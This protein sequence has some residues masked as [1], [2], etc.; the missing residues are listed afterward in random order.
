MIQFFKK[1]TLILLLLVSILISSCTKTKE[2]PD[3]GKYGV[4]VLISNEGTF[5]NGNGTISYYNSDNDSI[6]NEIFQLENNRSLGDVVQSVS[7]IGDY[8]FIQVNN[9][10]KIEVVNGKSFAE[11]GVIQNLT[12]VRY[13]IGDENTAFASAWGKW[14]VDGKVYFIDVNTLSVTDSVS[15]GLGS[16]AMVL[17][18]DK[19]FVANSGGWGFDNTI[20]IIDID[21]K[22]VL[23][24]LVVGANPK[25]MI[26]DKNESLWILC[27]GSALY[28]DN[29]NPIGHSPSK[30]FQ[31]N[32]IDYSVINEISLFEEQHPTKLSIN[33]EGD[34]LYIG[35]GFGFN[36]IYT[37]NINDASFAGTQLLNKSFY[38][39]DINPEDGVIFGYES[40]N[41][42]ERGKLFRYSETGVELGN[43]IVGIGPNGSSLKRN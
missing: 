12:Q 18:D 34:M 29:W 42:T 22:A 23:K 32:T 4:G 7:R 20:S 11:V 21:S 6:I 40:L 8:S 10:H 31:I 33:P 43:Y 35:A 25:S 36:G 13:S 26:I 14:G 28:D 41:F 39:F 38:G 3:Y 5:G 30:L 2:T 27:S 24:T 9:S 37:L 1:T 17:L 15:T 16:E 19:L